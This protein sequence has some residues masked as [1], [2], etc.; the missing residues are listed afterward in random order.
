VKCSKS[1]VATFSR[2]G[3]QLSPEYAVIAGELGLLA[4]SQVKSISLN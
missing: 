2:N 3:W 1:E 4:E